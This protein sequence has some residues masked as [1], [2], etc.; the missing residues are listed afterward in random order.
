MYKR[1]GVT[2]GI[3]ADVLKESSIVSNNIN[4][5]SDGAAYGIASC[6]IIGSPH[7]LNIRCV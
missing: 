2:E 5:I 4:I 6:N 7:D 3:Y 1:Q